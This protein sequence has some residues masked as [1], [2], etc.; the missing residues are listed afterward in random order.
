MTHLGD[1]QQAFYL[2]ENPLFTYV[3]KFISNNIYTYKLQ[4]TKFGEI[5]SKEPES[6]KRSWLKNDKA[7]NKTKQCLNSITSIS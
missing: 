2:V 5:F 4:Y 1:V 6:A 3:Q 7:S